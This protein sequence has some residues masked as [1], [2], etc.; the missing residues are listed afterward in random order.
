M[1]KINRLETSSCLQALL[2]ALDLSE[3]REKTSKS[4]Q[5]NRTFET[6]FLP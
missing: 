5:P 1:M 6:C 4:G 3:P 2:V